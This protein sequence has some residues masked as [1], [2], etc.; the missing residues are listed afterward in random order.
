MRTPRRGLRPLCYPLYHP[1]PAPHLAPSEEGPAPPP[2]AWTPS[3]SFWA[4]FLHSAPPP[5]CSAPAPYRPL[6]LTHPP[7]PPPLP[8]PGGRLLP[9]CFP[10][11]VRCG[12]GGT[13]TWGAVTW[14]TGTWGT[15]TWGAIP[16]YRTARWPLRCLDIPLHRHNSSSSSCNS[17][18][19]STC[20][21]CCIAYS[22]NIAYM[23]LQLKRVTHC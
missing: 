3:G 10:V 14:G 17:S 22:G 18:S 16:G 9:L 5:Y 7:L 11:A 8:P 15:G 12:G 21:S 19:S 20:N 2:Q 23:G 13:G 1:L 6:P 4:A